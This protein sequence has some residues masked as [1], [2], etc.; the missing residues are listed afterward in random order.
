[1]FR[2]NQYRLNLKNRTH[3]MGVLNITPDSFHKE[4]RVKSINNALKRAEKMIHEGADILDIGGES[5]R[6]GSEPV[7]EDEELKRI[8]PAIKAIIKK[9]DIPLSVDTYKYSVA[10][11]VLQEGVSIINDISG[12]HFSPE[13]APTIASS[14]AGVIIMH[15]S[16]KPKNMHENPSYKNLMEE[17]KSYLKEGVNKATSCGIEEDRI[18]IDPGI[19]FG[20]NF[21]HNISIMKKLKELKSLNKPVLLGLSRKSFIGKILNLP[22]EERLEGSLA[23]SVIGIINGAQILRTHDVKET[24]RAVA[25]ADTILNNGAQEQEN[26]NEKNI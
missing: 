14:N 26:R 12:L 24:K 19:G 15:I 22:V 11:T 21:S 9:F 5:T 20:K 16:G 4:S 18:I 8:L 6:P 2:C 23:A 25:V 7:P 10:K 3:I 1:M 13:M 17:I